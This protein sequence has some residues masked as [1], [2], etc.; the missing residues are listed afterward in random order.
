MTFLGHI[1]DDLGSNLFHRISVGV[2]CHNIMLNDEESQILYGLPNNG[3]SFSSNWEVVK[4]G[5]RN[6]GIAE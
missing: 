1:F 6:N 5:I 4:R 2:L 3:E